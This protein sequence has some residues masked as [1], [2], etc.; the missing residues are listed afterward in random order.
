MTYIRMEIL[1]TF[2]GRRAF[3]FSF[4]FPLVLFWVIA[5]PQADDDIGQGLHITVGLYYMV[6][7]AAYGAMIA[8]ASAGARIAAERESGWTRQLRISP[9]PVFAYFRTK[10][11]VAYLTAV[12]AMLLL[13]ASGYVEGVRIGAGRW[14]EMTGLILV[15][16]VPFAALGIWLGHVLTTDAM[17]PALGGG[18][19]LLALVGGFWFPITDG[20][21]HDAGQLLPSWWLVQASHVALGGDAWPAKGWAVVGFW[22]VALTLA[23]ARAYRRDSGRV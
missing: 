22:A 8:T 21:I 10:V 4:V 23:A 18:I 1:R 16:L 3:V 17:G 11:L 5:A 20:F 6:T 7:M 9:L 12:T 14:L 13:Y 15:G 19:G 2:R